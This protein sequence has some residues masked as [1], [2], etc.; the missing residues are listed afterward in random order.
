M[1]GETPDTFYAITAEPHLSRPRVARDVDAGV[2]IVGGGFA[3]LWTARALARRGYD[4]VV[5]EGRTIGGEA[6]G[7]NG[8]FVSAGYAE[9]LSRIV[10]RVGLDHAK[11]LY[12]LSRQ[13]MDIVANAIAEGTPGVEPVPGRLN[14]MRYDNEEEARRHA[15][16]LGEHF[17]HE[18][19]V[20]PTE[21][22][23]ETLKTERYYQALHDAEAFSVHPLNLA[24]G[25]AAEIEK[26]GGRIFENTVATGADLEGVRKWVETA[27]GR[28]R[29][30]AVVF[31]GSAFIGDGFPVLARTILPVAT[32]VCVTER[33]GERIAEAIRYPGGIAD[34]RRANDYYRV[35]GERLLW[36]GRITT[37]TDVPRRLRQRMARDIAR[38]YPTLKGIE[39]EHAWSGIMGYAIHRMPQIGMLRPGAWVASA[40]G[41]HGINASAI[42]GELIAAGIADNDERWRQ[43]VPF[44][45]VWAGGSIGRRTTQLVYWGMQ[46][47]DKVRETNA[48]R[49]E[50]LVRRQAAR[51]AARK[52]AEEKAAEAAKARAKEEAAAQR[53]RD[54]ERL[55]ELLAREEEAK[56]EKESNGAAKKPRGRSKKKSEG[57]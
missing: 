15:D 44:G 11:A 27:H 1:T 13:G 41:G 30:Q 52:V 9:R 39:I 33:N 36:G 31:C 10:E 19:V 38:V 4:V 21:R 12:A 40:F 28:V 17:G 43:F 6:S 2:C 54:A 14:V 8:G 37:R 51:E 57:E 55:A 42:A 48:W 26:L 32:F 45:L 3:G 7:R 50:W 56:A 49:K 25:L 5:L 34:T 24:Y 16:Y 18:M 46:L 22:V 20:W 53:K 23:R 47:G 29:A 35:V